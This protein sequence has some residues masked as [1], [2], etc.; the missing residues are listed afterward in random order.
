MVGEF[1]TPVW[2]RLVSIATWLSRELVAQIDGPAPGPVEIDPVTR[3]RLLLALLAIALMGIG[4]IVMVIL[5]GRMV[6]RRLR[7]PPIVHHETPVPPKRIFR[8]STPSE[9]DTAEHEDD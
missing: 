7:L 2:A 1:L 4:L 8:S 6:R 3:G 5:G 9:D